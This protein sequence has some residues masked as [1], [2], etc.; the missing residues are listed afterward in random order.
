MWKPTRDVEADGGVKKKR[1]V[2]KLGLGLAARLVQNVEMYYEVSNCGFRS[3]V[4]VVLTQPFNR[5]DEHSGLCGLRQRP[6]HR[7]RHPEQ[8]ARRHSH[9]GSHYQGGSLPARED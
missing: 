9:T 7:K 8:A 3:F 2:L 1:R 6:R 5:A 4:A